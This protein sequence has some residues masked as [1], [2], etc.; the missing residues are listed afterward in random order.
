M[1]AQENSK[2]EVPIW[3]KITLTIE[4]ANA[5]SGIGRDKIYEL[6]K[7]YPTKFVI[8]NGKRILIKR[9]EFEEFISNSI[10]I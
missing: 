9:K 5:L 2:S 6:A 10:T 3:R 4:E 8:K 7:E 1:V